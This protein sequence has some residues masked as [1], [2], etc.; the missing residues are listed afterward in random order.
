MFLMWV[1]CDEVKSR[2]NQVFGIGVVSFLQDYHDCS[3]NICN[4]LEN[5]E[6]LLFR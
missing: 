3:R 5:Q 4:L 1:V 6:S 2:D